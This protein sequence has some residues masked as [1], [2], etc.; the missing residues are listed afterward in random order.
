VTTPDGCQYQNSV[1]ATMDPVITVNIAT[2]QQITC[3]VPQISLNATTSVFQPG[4]TFLWTATGGGNIVSGANTL[5][6]VVNNSG[7]YTLT[8][9]SALG[10]VKQGSVN[11]I[12]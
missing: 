7:T 6:P 9:T 10:C 5:S 4:S 12:K 8:I 1:T 2:P 11:V 3:S